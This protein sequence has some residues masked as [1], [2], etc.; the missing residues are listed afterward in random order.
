MSR[1]K[2]FTLIE[3]LVVIAIIALLIG[4][5]LPAVQAAREAARRMQCTNNLKQIGLA[6]HNYESSN[7]AFP[8]GGESTDY[9]SNPPGTQFIDGASTLTRILSNLEQ[10]AVYQAYNYSL[11]YNHVSGANM[12]AGSLKLNV[13]TCPSNPNTISQGTDPSDAF[14]KASGLHYGRTDYGPTVYT[15]I[16]PRG[17]IQTPLTTP[18]TPYRNKASRVDGALAKGMTLMAQL[19]DGLSQTIVVAEDAGRNPTYISPYVEAY[20]TPTKT[21]PTRP[22]PQGTRRFWRWGEPD[23]GFG[24]SG[25]VNNKFKPDHEATDYPNPTGAITAGNNAG[26]NDEI[27]SY[28]AGGAN[29]LQADGSVKFLRETTNLVVIRSLVSRA[30]GEVVSSDQY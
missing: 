25:Q 13:Y 28:H 17:A 18:A 29:V 2:G 3:L 26:A 6:L 23:N 21:I 16:D 4:L 24:V 8:P 20:V 11:D 5:L 27:F 22:V 12:T 7:G 1:K 10:T 14:S 9:T 30:G 19:Q 15:D